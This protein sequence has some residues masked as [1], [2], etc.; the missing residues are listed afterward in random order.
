MKFENF[1]LSTYHPYFSLWSVR[2]NT[3]HSVHRYQSLEAGRQ[4]MSE[5]QF[6]SSTEKK[7]KNQDTLV[8]NKVTTLT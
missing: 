7:D 8:A 2:V 3:M 1:L 5:T 4:P 6:L